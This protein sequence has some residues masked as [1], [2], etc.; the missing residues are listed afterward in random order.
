MPLI[1][2]V[3]AMLVTLTV[4]LVKI[5]VNALKIFILVL[6]EHQLEHVLKLLVLSTVNVLVWLMEKLSKST[7]QMVQS[8]MTSM[9]V[10]LN[11]LLQADHFSL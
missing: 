8:V 10:T 2:N 11:V 6:M 3:L 5:L 4:P 9:N 1:S 7:L